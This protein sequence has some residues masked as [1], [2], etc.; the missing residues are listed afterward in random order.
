RHGFRQQNDA[1]LGRAV[2]GTHAASDEAVDGGG[3]DD[4]AA[5][6]REH[7][8]DRVLAPHELAFQVDGDKPVED[9]HVEGDDV[10]VD[11]VGRGVGRVVGHYVEADDSVEDASRFDPAVEDVGQQFLDVGADGCRAAADGDVVEERRL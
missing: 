3:V 6:A 5:S 11:G 7:V 8:R 4:R 1:G 2:G 10:R 9:R